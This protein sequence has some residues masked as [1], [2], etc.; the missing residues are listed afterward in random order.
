MASQRGSGGPALAEGVN[1]V[2][3]TPFLLQLHSL[4]PE[5]QGLDLKLNTE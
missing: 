2:A 4:W 1:R 5:L 3:S